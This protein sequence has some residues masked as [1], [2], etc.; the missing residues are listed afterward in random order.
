MIVFLVGRGGRWGAE[1]GRGGR[2]GGG[3]DGGRDVGGVGFEHLCV[4]LKLP[5]VVMVG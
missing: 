4:M 5:V 3:G 2:G 1:G